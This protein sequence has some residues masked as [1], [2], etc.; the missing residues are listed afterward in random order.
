MNRHQTI[1]IAVAAANLALML[2]FL[3]YDAISITRG[4]TSFDA[5]YFVFD[6][7]YNKQINSNLLYL[8][9]MWILTNAAAGWLFLR[10]GRSGGLRLRARAGVLAFA[11]ANL[12]LLLAFVPFETYTSLQRNSLPA[13]DGF[14][15]ILGD[16]AHRGIYVPLL[17]L[18]SFLLAINSAV[19]WLAF[20]QNEAT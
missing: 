12:A 14:Y 1:L 5:F 10:D 20:K 18:E 6:R 11:A 19:L 15:F 17:L 2:A 9:F 8:E 13:F 3:P 16:K 7:Q 4:G